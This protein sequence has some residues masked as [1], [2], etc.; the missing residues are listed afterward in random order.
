MKIAI[1]HYSVAPVVG[2][3]EAVIQA[4][5]LQFVKAGFQVTLIAGVGEQG[6]LPTGVEFIHVPLMDS[7]HK[8]IVQ[9]S[10]ALEA[11]EVPQDFEQLTARLQNS[12]DPILE[13][14]DCTIIHNIFTKHFNLP[15][16]AALNRSLN[17]GKLKRCICWG[18]DFTFTSPH[19]RPLVHSGYPWDLLRSYRQDVTYVTV[20]KQRQKELA[21]LFN[22]PVE[23]IHVIYDGVDPVELYSLST[24]GQALLQRLNLDE[25]DLILLMPV[26]ITQAKNI[27]DMLYFRSL[28]D[29]RVA[30]GVEQ[31]V[32]FVYTSGPL[33]EEGYTIDL[34]LVMELYRVSDALFMP[35]HR[36]GF[37]MPILEAG[38][39][40]KPI[41]STY[42]PAAQ[43]IGGHE[44]IYFS[45]DDPP[46]KVAMLLVKWAQA[47]PIQQ[48]RRRLRQKFTWHSIF[49]HDILP[50]LTGGEVV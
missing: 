13:S 47:S 50:L 12:L 10:Q 42:I 7:R 34:S 37:G 3:V 16:T 40:G 44:V 26:R 4:H 17:L 2:G 46:D 39:I 21:D 11:G 28:L 30:L 9:A 14:F 6:A 8:R 29:L 31:N 20:S 15:L 38:M 35:S 22:C 25:A 27:E 49:K 48:L 18:H 23:H 19:S 1:L 43:E 5:A 36:E 32:H 45:D 33:P 41:F 24:E